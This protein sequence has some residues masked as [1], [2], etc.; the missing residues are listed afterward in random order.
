MLVNL[1][2]MEQLLMVQLLLVCNKLSGLNERY[3]QQ[4]ISH[5]ECESDHNINAKM[6]MLRRVVKSWGVV[7]D[8]TA[9]LARVVY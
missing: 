5:S 9:K 7:R 4:S 1:S 6:K 8:P 3:L 2:E